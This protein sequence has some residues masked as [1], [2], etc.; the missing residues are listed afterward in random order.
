[1]K[2]FLFFLLLLAMSTVSFCQQTIPTVPMSNKYLLKS[3]KQKTAASGLLALGAVFTGAGLIINAAETS[4]Y[5]N[6]W[7]DWGQNQKTTA[8]GDVLIVTGLVSMIGSIPLF[9]AASKNKGKG[10]VTTGFKIEKT[11][12][13]VKTGYQKLSYPVIALKINF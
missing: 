12:Y 13:A 8:V 7:D 2:Q 9:T 4:Y 3:K 5:Y 10:Q 11:F 6:D 1:M